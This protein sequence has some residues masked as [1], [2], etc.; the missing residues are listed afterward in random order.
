LIGCGGSSAPSDEELKKKVSEYLSNYKRL[1]WGSTLPFSMLFEIENIS[2]DDKLITG[3]TCKAIFDI[4]VKVKTEY[5]SKSSVPTE[6]GYAF[7]VGD[8]VGAKV[9]EIK[10]SQVIFILNEY[11]NGWKIEKIDVSASQQLKPKVRAYRK[12]S[13]EETEKMMNRPRFKVNDPIIVSIPMDKSATE[14]KNLAVTFTIIVDK[15]ESEKGP[16]FDLM[17]ALKDESFLE[18]AEKLKP[19]IEADVKKI[20]MTYTFDELQQESIKGEFVEKLIAKLNET[21]VGFGL[22]PRFKELLITSFIFSK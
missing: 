13:Q 6:S 2:V 4:S 9:G 21:L 14:F 19:L 7:L 15:L 5:I 10:S 8:A 20:A 16:D 12:Y 3:K 17:V 1:A 22:K 11:D 18:T